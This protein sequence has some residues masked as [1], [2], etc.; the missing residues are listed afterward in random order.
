MFF[1][2]DKVLITNLRDMGLCMLRGNRLL[3]VVVLRMGLLRLSR[4]GFLIGREEGFILGFSRRRSICMSLFRIVSRS[5]SGR[6]KF[7]ILLMKIV[8]K[9]MI[10]ILYARKLGN[11]ICIIDYLFFV[12]LNLIWWIKW[13]VILLFFAFSLNFHWS[14]KIF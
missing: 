13:F 12:F 5:G 4:R 8:F 10:K 14:I 6:R 7:L 11:K 9:N 1:T 3:F 2:K